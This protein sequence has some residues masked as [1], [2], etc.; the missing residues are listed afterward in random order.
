MHMV[1]RSLPFHLLLSLPAT[2]VGF[3]LAVQISAL[4]WILTTQYGLHIEEVGLV[5]AAGPLAGI[6]GQ[7][8][9]GIISDKTWFWGGRRKPFIFLGGLIS[10]P[11]LLALPNLDAVGAALGLEA[12]LGIA[13][14]VALSLDL[15]I[16]VSFNPART[17]I[18]DVTE[19]GAE[20]TRSY[21]WMQTVSG[22][23]G[24]LAYAIGALYGNITLIYVAV[25]VVLAFSLIPPLF[26]E[27]PRELP[28]LSEASQGESSLWIAV[29][30]IKPLWGFIAYA[31]YAMPAR[32]LG[33]SFDHLWIEYA[34]LG[35]T[36]VMMASN[37]F[38]DD[39]S[40]PR[41]GFQKVAT[42]NALSW[43][44]IQTMFV[45]MIAYVQTRMPMLDDLSTGEVMSISFLIL[46][47]VGAIFPTLILKPIATRIGSAFTMAGCTAIMAFGY[48]GIT[49]SATSAIS[50]YLWMVVVGIGW[51]GVVSLPFDVLSRNAE[52]K[53]LGLFM[54][55]F[56][57]SIVLPQ[58]F[59][60][61]GIGLMVGAMNDQGLIFV[62][63][64]V[65][66]ALSAI[67]W[68]KVGERSRK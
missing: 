58:L 35:F 12:L 24:V 21:T 18:A 55:L 15:A 50:L 62:I 38:S 46:N 56:N 51:A 64:A 13:I 22:T 7:V 30:S 43:V 3:A 17:L 11:M 65:S 37:L 49:A 8:L 27:E 10:A 1:K 31:L 48:L 41:S 26:I 19:E 33:V 57:L 40:N 45:Y 67:A 44:G 14:L 4:S 20:R 39:S 6:I 23:F 42:A 53:R 28:E 47:A 5:W 68:W 36:L 34:A 32:V 61:L 29:Q 52:P 59:V 60:S 2:G 9:I 54:G 16:N 63:S 66:L 25:V